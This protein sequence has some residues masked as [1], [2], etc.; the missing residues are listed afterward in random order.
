MQRVRWSEAQKQRALELFEAHGP[1]EASR[2]T[3]IPI[4]TI[5][6][7]AKRLGRKSVNPERIEVAITRQMTFAER[8][9]S[10]AESLVADVLRLKAQLFAPTVEKK[11][12][13]VSDGQHMGSHIEVA[14]VELDQPSFADQQRITASMATLLDKAMLLAGEAT[15]RTETLTAVSDVQASALAAVRELRSAS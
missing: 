6:S 2:Q 7:W 3:G 1:G 8:K 11:P 9:Q 14:E 4:G 13:I 15:A 5:A 10:L 12:M